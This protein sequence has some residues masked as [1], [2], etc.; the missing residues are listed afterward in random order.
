LQIAPATC[1]LPAMT[2][3][4]AALVAMVGTILMAVLLAW[5]FF[6]DVLNY[7]HGLIP[8]VTLLSAFIYAFGCFTVALFFYVFYKNQA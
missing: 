6:F 4:N 3:K 7:L 8:A 1:I 2:L 5:K